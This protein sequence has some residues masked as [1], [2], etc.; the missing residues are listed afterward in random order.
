MDINLTLQD[1]LKRLPKF[2]Y[3]LQKNGTYR[4]SFVSPLDEKVIA[5]YEQIKEKKERVKV[6]GIGFKIEDVDSNF[7]V[8]RIG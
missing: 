3:V 6:N 5:K 8:V 2:N 4:L 1:E 7:V